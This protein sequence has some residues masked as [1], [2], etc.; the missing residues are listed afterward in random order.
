MGGMIDTRLMHTYCIRNKNGIEAVFTNYGQRLMSLTVPDKEGK[1]DDVVLG[2]SSP[3]DYCNSNEFYY[4]AVVGRYCNRIAK[5]KFYIDDLEYELARNNGSHH[6]HGGIQCFSNVVWNVESYTKDAISFE[7]LS[8]D[9]EEGYPGNLRVQVDYSLTDE[10]ELIIS[11]RATTDKKTPVN[12]THHSY[13]NLAGEGNGNINEH[14]LTINADK[15]TESD[16]ESIPTGTLAKVSGT[17]LDFRKAKAIGKDVD[18]EHEQI[19]NRD[20]YD[21]NF[22]LNKFP[23]DRL[24]LTFAAK[25]VEPKTKRMLEVYTTEPGLQFYSSNY[26]DG[27]DVG[28]SGKSYIKRGAFCLEAQH[29]PD[30]PN[31]TSFPN[32]ILSPNQFFN[33]TTLYRFGID[34]C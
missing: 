23:R 11:Y 31:N 19:M 10:N 1:F 27:S 17:P 33:S 2:Y 24:G 18:V 22:V 15:F 21:H 16:K 6:L 4:G 12:L 26:L 20:G 5:G 3:M 29:F 28:K 9:G 7:R 14:L 34:G 30:S 25:V 13:F 32:T 8:P